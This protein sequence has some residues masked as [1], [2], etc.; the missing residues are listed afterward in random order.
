M[1]DF[2]RNTSVNTSTLE[3][4]V[5]KTVDT[6]INFSPLTLRLLG[7][8]KSWR[9]SKLRMPIKHARNTQGMSFDGLDRFATTKADNFINMEFDPTGRQIPCVISQMEVDVNATNRVVDLV[10]RQ[11][12]SDAQDIA[13]DIAGLF[14]TLQTGKNFLS[15]LDAVDDGG[16][17]A[18]YGGLARA[19]FLGIRGNVTAAVGLLT[20]GRMRTMM[21]SCTHGTESPDL[22]VCPRPVWGFYESLL[23]PT[24]I[25]Q[26]AVT[27]FPQLTRTG[28]APGV[29]SLKGQQGFDAIY[30][31]GKPVVA[32]DRAPAGNMF[33]LN[34][35]RIAF[36]GLK[37]T[38]PDYKTVKF[39]G[40]NIDGVYSDAPVVNGFSFSGFN[41]PV[42]QYGSVGHILLMGNLI[43]NSP[44]HLGRL[45]G[46]TGV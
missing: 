18:T 16:L 21:N 13:D 23:T 19:T 42:D 30:Y 29:Q 45:L 24:V 34:T 32:D 37:S 12:E 44:R 41:K 5:A 28:I 43:A 6:V 22:I 11:L 27:G 20:L 15:V 4:L 2:A 46:I 3:H 17:R 39:T 35:N 1:Q 14:Y 26:I 7:N 25:N 38:D 10:A 36:Y 9:G 31:S 8:Q 33:F 40:Q